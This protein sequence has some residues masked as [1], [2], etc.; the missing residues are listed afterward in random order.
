MV[1][2]FF[3]GCVFYYVIFEGSYFFGKFLQWQVNI[4]LG[5][6]SF[7]CLYLEK[8]E[9]V[10]VC[11]LI[12][13]MIVMDFQKCFLV[14]YVLKYLF[15]WSLE[16]QFQFFQDVSDRIEKEFL[17]GL[18]VKQLERGG[19]VVVKMDWWENIIVFFQIDL[20]KFRI[21]K[22]GFVRDFF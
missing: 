21:Y 19:R 9:D 14:K 3:V 1:D 17:D 5:V 6:C 15:F 13:K 4:F 7:E 22:G 16:K 2:I 10:I 8:Y 20:C 18:I 12:E 11:E